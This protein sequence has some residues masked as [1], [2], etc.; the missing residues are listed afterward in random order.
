[1][2]LP[3]CRVDA[4]APFSEVCVDH[5]Y[6]AV[7]K[8]NH[9]RLLS[10]WHDAFIPQEEFARKLPVVIKRY[11]EDK[12]ILFL[13]EIEIATE[14]LSALAEKELMRICKKHGNTVKIKNTSKQG[15][16]LYS[17]GRGHYS[18]DY[19]ELYDYALVTISG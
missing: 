9:A 1:M 11:C 19:Y 12:G 16:Y 4:D 5:M 15:K 18:T 6:I 8:E 3:A 14:T 17:D 13:D 2:I 7:T 10:G